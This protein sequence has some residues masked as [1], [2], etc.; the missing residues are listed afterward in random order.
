[1]YATG[2]CWGYMYVTG[3][4]TAGAFEVAALGL[5][6]L[7]LRMVALG[8]GMGRTPCVATVVAG[9]K[10]PMGDMAPGMA[11]IGCNNIENMQPVSKPQPG[12][13][14]SSM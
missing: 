11:G 9:M 10:G 3:I 13:K 6:T 7:W 12:L 14:S 1:M 4:G 5:Y 8:G 2:H